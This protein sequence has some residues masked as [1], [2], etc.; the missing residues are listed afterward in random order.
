GDLVFTSQAG[1][2]LTPSARAFQEIMHRVLER[3]GFP[4]VKKNGRAIRYITFHSL[5]H[6]FASHWM[7]NGGDIFKLQKVLGHQ[8]ITMTER[9]SHLAPGAFAGDLQRLGR[10][11][12]GHILGSVVPWAR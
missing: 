9:Y 11:P 8:S 1:T 3:G 12:A 4:S 7:M 2:M 10:E 6:S 5:R